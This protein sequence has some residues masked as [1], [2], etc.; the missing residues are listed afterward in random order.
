MGTKMAAFIWGRPFAARSVTSVCHAI[1]IP[2]LWPRPLLSATAQIINPIRHKTFQRRIFFPIAFFRAIFPVLP[3]EKKTAR[4]VFSSQHPASFPVASHRERT[5]VTIWA[6]A[7]SCMWT[8]RAGGELEMLELNLTGDGGAWGRP[9][10]A[11][12]ARRG[13]WVR[14]MSVSSPGTPGGSPW[15]QIRTVSTDSDRMQDVQGCERI[16]HLPSAVRN[17]HAGIK[18]Q[19]YDP[20]PAGNPRRPGRSAVSPFRAPTRPHRFCFVWNFNWW[21]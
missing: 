12:G 13:D 6:S 1:F 18:D 3:R 4:N 21:R 10:G 8:G 5:G 15:P 19:K 9:G 14:K 20:L 2:S 17:V 16:R 7:V 11:A